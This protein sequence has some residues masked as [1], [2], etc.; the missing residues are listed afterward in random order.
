MDIALTKIDSERHRLVITR[1]DGSKDEVVL[2]TR[3]LLVHDLVHYAVEAEAG[4]DDGFWGLLASGTRI[5]EFGDRSMDSSISP[6]IKLA[7]SLV[8]PMQSLV[9]DRL[10]PAI[11]L[12]HG[13]KLAPSIV[14]EDFVVRVRERFRQ[15][16]GHWRGT[17]FHEAMKLSWPARSS[18][19]RETFS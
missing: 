2:E 14:N 4:I 11:F 19:S 10:D 16:L 7:E 5:A 15:L 9:Q 17:P 6:G 1:D 18:T 8:G 12:E 3:S 13:K